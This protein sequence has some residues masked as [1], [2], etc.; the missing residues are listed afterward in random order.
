VD[1][2]A[3]HSLA[4]AMKATSVSGPYSLTRPHG[5]GD[6]LNEFMVLSLAGLLSAA[7]VAI[8]G[9][10]AARSWRFVSEFWTRPGHLEFL[11]VGADRKYLVSK[12]GMPASE[13]EESGLVR[14]LFW[15]PSHAVVLVTDTAGDD[16]VGWGVTATRRATRFTIRRARYG[17]HPARLNWTTLQKMQT[18]D[19][20]EERN[21]PASNPADLSEWTASQ[22]HATNWRGEQWGVASGARSL[23]RFDRRY[24]Y[25]IAPKEADSRDPYRAMRWLVRFTETSPRGRQKINFYAQWRDTGNSQDIVVRAL[26]PLSWGD[27]DTLPS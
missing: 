18:G 4:L 1:R 22:G 14:E 12:L 5:R 6:T 17:E 16:V 9:V 8:L 2:A 24:S 7:A 3:V 19:P 13:Y 20:Q 10:V 25:S 15:F 11:A 26:L 21:V 23:R 27:R